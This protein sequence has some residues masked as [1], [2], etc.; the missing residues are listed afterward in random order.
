MACFFLELLNSPPLPSL[1]SQLTSIDEYLAG[2][3]PGDTGP[4]GFSVGWSPVQFK[5][6]RRPSDIQHPPS[7]PITPQPPPLCPSLPT[8]STSSYTSPAPDSMHDTARCL[9]GAPCSI[10][11][12]FGCAPSG[13]SDEY[14]RGG[15]HPDEGHAWLDAH[16][17]C[18]HPTLLPPP[19]SLRHRNHQSERPDACLCSAD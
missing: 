19:T 12:M 18:E 3:H 6:C 14:T 11:G 15:G 9:T 17:F 16:P 7:Q 1:S 10:A 8:T 4:G 2:H 5:A 13:S